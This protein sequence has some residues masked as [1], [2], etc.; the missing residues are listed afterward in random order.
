MATVAFLI[1]TLVAGIVQIINDYKT[2][3]P[4]YIE[5][6]IING[7]ESTRTVSWT[8]SVFT[9]IILLWFIILN[10]FLIKDVYKQKE[11]TLGE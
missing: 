6:V 10:L 11:I 8:E 7:V 5:T 9:M 2:Y 3:G 4:S 1:V